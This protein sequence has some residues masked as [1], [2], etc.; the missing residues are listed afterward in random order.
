M[1]PCLKYGGIVDGRHISSEM[2]GVL[3]DYWYSKM[4]QPVHI[5]SQETIRSDQDQDL[6]KSISFKGT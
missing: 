3:W 1:A 5:A 6:T 4:S 2:S